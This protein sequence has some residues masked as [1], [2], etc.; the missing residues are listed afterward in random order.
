MSPPKKADN[1]QKIRVKKK[2]ITAGAGKKAMTAPVE[3]ADF[4]E[5]ITRELTQKLSSKSVLLNIPIW[6]WTGDGKTCALITAIHFCD[7]AQH[8]LGFS[9]ATNYDELT[10]LENSTEE[11]RGLNL[12]AI[13]HST[14]ERLRTLSEMFI[15]RNEWPPGTDEP[16]SYVL[17]IRSIDATL[18]FVLFPDIKG[19]SFRE[20]DETA[21]EV[22]RKAHAAV[23]LV[24]PELYD[25]K[26]TDGKRYRDEILSRL[27]Q[28]SRARVPVCVMITKADL[29]QGPNHATDNTHNQLTMV[30]E[31]QK[32]LDALVCRVSVVGLDKEL[33]N[34]RLPPVEQR[35]PDNLLKAWM[36]VVAKALCR[37]SNEI[38]SL[39]PSVN[40]R[41]VA[42]RPV[43]YSAV[44]VPEL[45][46]AGDFSNSPGP[47]LCP[48]SDDP[49]S[50]SFAFLAE[51]GQL[52]E[53]TVALGV[54]EEPQFR[55]LGNIPELE[56]EKGAIQGYYVDGE[57]F[58]GSSAKCNFIWQGA[59]G[60]PLSKVPF[61]FEMVSWAPVSPRRLVGLDSTGRLH[62][63]RLEAGKWVQADY[64]E[65]FIASSELLKC[66]F[67]DASSHVVAFNGEDVQ[68]V[69]LAPDGRF[70][71][72]IDIEL[73]CKYDMLYPS[74]NRLGLCVAIRE[75]E[76][77]VLSGPEKNILLGKVDV[78]A[79]AP[80]A[81]ASG[82]SVIAVVAPDR[83]L[84]VVYASAGKTRKSADEYS[85]VLQ[86]TPE[87]MVW[88]K[89]GEVL[90]VTLDDGTW[91]VFRPLGF[92]V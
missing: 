26:M 85:P 83:R 30:V 34:N 43:S 16:S 71:A 92:G 12:A 15:D 25:K 19:G 47:V 53:A 23:L 66:E 13:A 77:A 87:S 64:V 74:V 5:Q 80:I 82:A 51:E 62:S 48:S 8:P 68:G 3:E 38:L 76:G 86:S 61:P 24:N 55:S 44:A 39:V 54:A 14:T 28:F 45:R 21:Q 57:F 1:P 78:N 75:S 36:W 22:L 56:G 89:N 35:K 84:S 37:P 29:H 46:Q 18:G 63:F 4:L 9:L 27:Q 49:R 59:K 65:G 70:G 90:I 79:V 52:Y 72:R 32:D 17:A 60:G 7:P 31:R 6:G 10:A 42:E 50:L 73:V 41:A 2:A 58:V 91:G 81:I 33:D 67:V 88:A 40:I 11:Y 20:L 69:A